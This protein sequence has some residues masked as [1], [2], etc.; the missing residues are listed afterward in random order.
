MNTTTGTDKPREDWCPE[1]FEW[2]GHE[3]KEGSDNACFRYV[4]C[5]MINMTDDRLTYE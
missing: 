5:D 3:A 2:N 1:E 4:S